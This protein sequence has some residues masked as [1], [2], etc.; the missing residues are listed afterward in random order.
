MPQLSK[1]QFLDLF[2]EWRDHYLA[3][4]EVELATTR[5]RMA[6]NDCKLRQP[7]DEQRR[8]VSN[9]TTSLND[10]FTCA[11]GEVI[12]DPLDPKMLE[13]HGPH[14]QAASLPQV[15]E[16]LERWREHGVAPSRRQAA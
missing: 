5:K 8:R 9:R 7:M 2:H 12:A 6:E 11:C 16:H 1:E 4:L 10:V 13:L 14:F 15:H 3:R